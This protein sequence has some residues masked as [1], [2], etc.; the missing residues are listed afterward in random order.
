MNIVLRRIITTDD[1]KGK[2]LEEDGWA[3]KAPENEVGFDQVRIKETF[4]EAKKGVTEVSTS[5]I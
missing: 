1:D 2:Q 4:M 3:H 5:G